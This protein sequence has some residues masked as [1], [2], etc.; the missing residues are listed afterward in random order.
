MLLDATLNALYATHS[1]ISP[2]VA[3]TIKLIVFPSVAL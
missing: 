1:I 2:E 3:G